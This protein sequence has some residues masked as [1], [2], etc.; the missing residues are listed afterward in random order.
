M[1]ESSGQPSMYFPCATTQCL[2][3]KNIFQNW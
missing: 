3:I 2:A 1:A